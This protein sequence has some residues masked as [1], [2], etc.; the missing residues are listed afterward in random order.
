M[1]FGKVIPSGEKVIFSKESGRP[2]RFGA[3][4]VLR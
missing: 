3:K 4:A 1:I 2:A